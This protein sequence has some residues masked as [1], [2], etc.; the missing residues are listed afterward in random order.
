MKGLAFVRKKLFT[1]EDPHN[2]HKFLGLYAV[3]S[4]IYRYIYVTIVKGQSHLGF[5]GTAFDWL[6]IGLHMSLS[7]SS[8]IFHVLARRILKRPMIIWE[9]YRLHAIVF[10]MRT[11]SCFVVGY[12][13]ANNHN[14]SPWVYALLPL[15]M[16]VH[17]LVVDEITRRHGT[18]GTTTVRIDNNSTPFSKFVLRVY[19]FYQFL[20]LA[21]M[22]IP[23]GNLNL[24]TI[25]FNSLIAIQSSAFLMTLYRKGLIDYYSHSFWY[26]LCLGFSAYHILQAHPSP[27]L[28]LAQT[29][30][31]YLLRVV[32][33]QSKY[34]VWGLFVVLCNPWVVSLLKATTPNVV[35]NILT[36]SSSAAV[37]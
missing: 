16:L 20:A 10:S 19:S 31:A 21:V 35:S 7:C 34:V 28:L 36:M 1:P 23:Y 22:L 2:M 14:N 29:A 12:F 9:E 3:I 5:T 6:T 11:A 26:T 18:T 15:V 24:M 25:G 37:M 27:R 8:L 17:H 33:R 32:G 13:T 4:F 30:L